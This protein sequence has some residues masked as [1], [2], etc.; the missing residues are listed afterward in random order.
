MQE[1]WPGVP[2]SSMNPTPPRTYG[3]QSKMMGDAWL[4]TE[5]GGIRSASPL[6]W[7]G[8]SSAIGSSRAARTWCRTGMSSRT[9]LP[10]VARGALRHSADRAYNRRA[11][12]TRPVRGKG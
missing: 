5:R 7:A 6:N 1:S 10:G 8:S 4:P 2:Q 12:R 9:R 11:Y 3:F